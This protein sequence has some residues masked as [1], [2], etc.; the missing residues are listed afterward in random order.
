MRFSPE[1]MALVCDTI[2]SLDGTL[3]TYSRLPGI[4]G[5]QI[6]RYMDSISGMHG[7]YVSVHSF[8]TLL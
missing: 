8:I 6:L 7:P 2:Y 3:L 1:W 4:G 5:A